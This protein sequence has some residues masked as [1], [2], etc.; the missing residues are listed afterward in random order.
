MDAPQPAIKVCT[1]CGKAKSLADFTPKGAAFASRCKPCLAEVTR[2][3]RV[4]NLEKARVRDRQYREKNPHKVRA[5]SRAHYQRNRAYYAAKNAE[6]TRK[7][8]EANRARRARYRARKAAA[9]GSGVTAVEWAELRVA[10]GCCLGCLRTDVPLEP[11]HVWA[12]ALGGPHSIDNIQPL[13]RSCNASKGT[14]GIDYRIYHEHEV[15]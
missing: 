1:K 2:E 6:W 15:V 5:A 10:Y 9:P 7:N 12:L 11:D 3:W 8:P 13:C 4:R 14:T